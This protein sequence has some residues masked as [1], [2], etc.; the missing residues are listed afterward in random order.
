MACEEW[1]KV[2]KHRHVIELSWDDNGQGPELVQGAVD[3]EPVVGPTAEAVIRRA[4]ERVAQHR[5]QPVSEPLQKVRYRCSFC[6]K[7]DDRG[8][9]V[10]CGPGGV[11]ACS[12]CV[13]L[14]QDELASRG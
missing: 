14:L 1:K 13:R 10:V 12:E 4:L 2:S 9:R 5:P 6:G 8:R 11:H 3:G 7:V